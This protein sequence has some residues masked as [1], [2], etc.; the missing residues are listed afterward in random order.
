M[1]PNR[2]QV[3]AW[4]R[5]AGLPK[6]YQ[7]DGIA[8]EALVVK[9]AALAY[10]EGAADMKERCAKVAEFVLKMPKNDV[11]TYIRSLGDDE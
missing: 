11:S 5:Q 8:N 3:I 6:W 10:A 4:A 9:Y 1:N 7:T 2:E